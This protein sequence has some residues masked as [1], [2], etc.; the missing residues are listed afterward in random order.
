MTDVDWTTWS[1]EDLSEANI[2]ID[3]E[4]RRRAS[5][6][7]IPQQMAQ[8]NAQY[9]ESSTEFDPG[10]PWVRPTA[11]Y[12]AYPK[13]WIATHNEKQWEST[14]DTNV[15]EP[16]VSGWRE[17][18][19]GEE[20]PAWTQ[21]TGGHDAYGVGDKVT[22]VSKHWSSNIDA[23]VWEPGAVGS[24]TLWTEHPIEQPNEWP[25][26]VQPTGAHDDYNL[27]DQVTHNANHWTS[28]VDGNIWE[29][30]VYGWTQKP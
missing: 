1:D 12:N 4:R 29:P 6:E 17:H 5:L 2:E 30:G 13:G 21:P 27:G 14:V 22:H 25:D 10:Q 23:N 3:A 26:W 24:E 19:V 28:D 7:H 15:W 18:V 8:L 16:G 9:M 11:A 20:W